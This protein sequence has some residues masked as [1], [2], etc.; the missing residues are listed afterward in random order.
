MSASADR[1][2][3]QVRILRC[4]TGDEAAFAELVADFGPRLCYFVR[5]LIGDSPNV[6]DVIQD[7]WLDVLRGLPRLADVRAFPAWIYRVARDRAWRTLRKRRPQGQPFPQD[8]IAAEEDAEFSAEDAAL[9]H[10][11]LDDLPPEQR[12]VLVLRFVEDMSYED[13]ARVTGS[14]LG[15]VRSRIH[16][17]KR[18]LRRALEKETCT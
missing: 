13:I 18:A 16:Y 4:Q 7:I 8:T 14:P 3:E 5:K 1:L 12:E 10:A 17:A 2:A 9:I 15:T 11:C 6:E